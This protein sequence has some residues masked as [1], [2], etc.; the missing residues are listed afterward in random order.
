[1]EFYSLSY[2]L[3]IW[4]RSIARLFGPRATTKEKK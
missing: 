4:Q 1:M 2:L 3:A